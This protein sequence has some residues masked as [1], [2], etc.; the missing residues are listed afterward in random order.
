MHQHGGKRKNAGRK[1]VSDPKKQVTVYPHSSEVENV[2]GVEAA[3]EIAI[4]AIQRKAKIL[5]NS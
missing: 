4:K 3:K 5:K 1:P 2:G